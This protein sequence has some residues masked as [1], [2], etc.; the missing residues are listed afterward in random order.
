LNQHFEI[1]KHH[2]SRPYGGHVVAC[3]QS[4]GLQ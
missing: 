4:C 3:I 1:P 2:Q